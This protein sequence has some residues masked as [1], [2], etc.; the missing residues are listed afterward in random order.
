[1]CTDAQ[2]KW[3]TTIQCM[4][5]GSA[6]VGKGCKHL[7]V[8]KG[9]GGV[10]KLP[11]SVFRALLCIVRSSDPQNRRQSALYT[12]IVLRGP[13]NKEVSRSVEVHKRPNTTPRAD[14]SPASTATS[15][16]RFKFFR[17]TAAVPAVTSHCVFPRYCPTTTTTRNYASVVH[18]RGA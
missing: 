6:K 7:E 16:I 15:S 1:M 13:K 11:D 14:S 4:D 18:F 3:D 10:F 2:T 12:C 5:M 17:G 8:N 9:R